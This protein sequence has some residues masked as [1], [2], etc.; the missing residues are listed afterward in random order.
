[1]TT[2]EK[3][4]FWTEIVNNPSLWGAI[5]TTDKDFNAQAENIWAVM[6][7]SFIKNGSF[8][9][10]SRWEKMLGDKLENA[11]K[12]TLE[13]RKSKILK[14]VTE[15]PPI[16][17]KLLEGKIA[18]ILGDDNDDFH[19]YYDKSNNT[20]T[21]KVLW[22]YED[23][24]KKLSNE[25]INPNVNYVYD[26]AGIAKDYLECYFIE[27]TGTQYFDSGFEPER[28]SA[29]TK[30]QITE[31]KS[32][33]LIA[34]YK[35]SGDSYSIGQ[36]V[37]SNGTDQAVNIR[38]IDGTYASAN[39][40]DNPIGYIGEAEINCE[41][42]YILCGEKRVKEGL[43]Q[44]FQTPMG[45]VGVFRQLPAQASSFTGRVFYLDFRKDGIDLAHFLPAIDP[46]GKPC[47]YNM[48]TNIPSYNQGSGTFIMGLTLKLAK[49][50]SRLPLANDGGTLT[51]SLP[52]NYT[53]DTQVLNALEIARQKGWTLTI[54]TYEDTSSSSTY[55]MRR[56]WVRKT[57]DENGN[58][59]DSE[60]KRFIVEW[61]VDVIT[62]EN[63]TPEE[64]GYEAFRDVKSAIEI[65][66]LSEWVDP[67]WERI[68]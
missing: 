36:G 21:I 7:E 43:G 61:C 51:I 65:W 5:Q 58:Y 68:I 12:E 3:E 50:L 26:F 53:E 29:K 39:R 46:T 22:D 4:Q 30:W 17:V 56:I 16:T 62:P 40:F 27:T 19:F 25:V 38:T 9:E 20:A 32:G 37:N 64:M 33:S 8:K 63:K 24:V 6:S 55:S 48:V 52:A 41:E 47:F 13:E 14:Q 31:R 45:T 28:L 49:R 2:V 15:H 18:E 35:Y 60:G 10:V 59:V 54:Q 11:G 66:E 23:D 67:E 57:E 44:G 1:M 42:N 34:Y